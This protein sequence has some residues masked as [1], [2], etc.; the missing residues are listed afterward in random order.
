MLQTV[1]EMRA[2]GR[3]AYAAK[4]GQRYICDR[5]G[6]IGFTTDQRK[7]LAFESPEQA[8]NVLQ[9]AA[10]DDRNARKL[11]RSYMLVRIG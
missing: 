1:G 2:S 11:G 5:A 8:D 4:K 3:T 10:C 9:A 6:E 7:A